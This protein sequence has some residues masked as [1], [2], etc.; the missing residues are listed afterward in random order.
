MRLIVTRVQPQA[1]TWVNSF[2]GK[3]YEALALPLIEVGPIANTTALALAWQH[4]ADYVAVMFVSSHAVNYFFA[5]KPPLAPVLIASSA[6]DT[7]AWATGPATR[8]ALLKQG[9]GA[10]LID[11]PAADGGQF[12]SEALWQQ[13]AARVKPGGKVLIVR[14]DSADA[15][16][17]NE[18]GVGRDWFAQQVQLSGASVDFVVAYR[19]SAPR[20]SE[21]EKSLA[22]SAARDGSVWILSSSEAV[23]HLQTLLPDQN[24]Q[25]ARAVATHARIALAARALGFGVVCESQPTLAAV[26]SSLES[27]A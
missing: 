21:A 2:Q 23:T 19:R 15:D 24:W 12:D 25:Q 3:G 8:T 1:Q 7:R 26:L 4:W 16:S 5:S 27:M 6:I 9:V 14:G 17:T 18:G 10:A 11:S 13:V 20:W 22:S